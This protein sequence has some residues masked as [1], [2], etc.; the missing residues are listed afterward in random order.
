MGTTKAIRNAGCSTLSKASVDK[1]P[2]WLADSGVL[3]NPALP[4]AK[5]LWASLKRQRQ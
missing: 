3:S 1:Q 2:Y 4:I 5:P